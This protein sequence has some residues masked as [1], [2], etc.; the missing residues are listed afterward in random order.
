MRNDA[1]EEKAVVLTAAERA[2]GTD[3]TAGPQDEN[4]TAEG[5][6]GGG[7]NRMIKAEG[8]EPDVDLARREDVPPSPFIVATNFD[9]DDVDCKRV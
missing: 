3:G 8:G 2:A 4:P 5:C 1:A 9:E 7:Q 6:D